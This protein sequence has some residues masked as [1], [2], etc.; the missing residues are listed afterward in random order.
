MKVDVATPAGLL[1]VEP[2]GWSG[3]VVPLAE[4][5]IGAQGMWPALIQRHGLVEPDLARVA[6]WWHTDLDRGRRFEVLTDQTRARAL[7]FTGHRSTLQSFADVFAR[8]REAKLI[9]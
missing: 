3:P 4:Q 6:S 8:Y 5:M 1:D 9:P 7:G 2:A